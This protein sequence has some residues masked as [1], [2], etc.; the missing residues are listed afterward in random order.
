MAKF[1]ITGPDGA[2]YEITAPDDASEQDVLAYAQQQFAAPKQSGAS[3]KWGAGASGQ[4][5]QPSGFKRGFVDDTI[6]A[7]KQLGSETEIAN[8]IAPEWSR[9]VRGETQA[10]EDA[11]QAARGKDAG[12][13]WSR[14]AGQVAN[15]VNLAISAITKTPPGMSLAGRTVASAAGGAAMGATAPV[16][17]EASR[18]EQAALG[19]AGGALA[20]PIAGAVSRVMKPKVS[21][22]LALLRSEGITPTIGQSFGPIVKR[23]E[24][25]AMSLPIVGDAIAMTRRNQLD[26]LNVAAFN[27]ALNPIG[28]KSSGK[29]GFGGMAEVH[30]K[31]NNAYNQLLPNLSFKPDAQFV[32]NVASLRSGVGQLDIADQRLYDKIIQRTMGQATPQGNMSGTT[33]K[34]VES[35]LGKEITRLAKDN[36]YGK[37]K[38]ME[39]LQQYRDELRQGLER[40][41][42][43]HA[44]KLKAINEGWANYAILRRAASGPAAAQTGG[45]TPSQLMQGVQES[46]KRSE[47]AV[48]RAKLSEGNALMQDLVSAAQQVLPSKYPDSGT[49]G[50]LF[51]GGGLAG[52]GVAGMPVAMQVAAGLSAASL[53]YLPGIRKGVDV[54]LNASRGKSANALADLLRTHPALLGPSV[55]PLLANMYQNGE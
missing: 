31:L 5:E 1:K 12:I 16:Y 8:L 49:A 55:S 6:N 17:G 26:Q 20:A 11:Y 33:F 41:N 10:D 25:L 46:A 54:A 38:V 23:Q 22:E 4:L 44:D 50:R 36:S 34:S 14:L 21:P 52:S 37:Q 3:G 39:A 53:P 19:G 32:N 48:G 2:T 13:D 47:Q 42:P 24:D 35:E 15:P 18:G 43:R 40:A 45:F 7:A 9:R 27:R 51:M 29:V 30:H 28:E